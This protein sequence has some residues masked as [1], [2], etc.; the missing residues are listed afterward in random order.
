MATAERQPCPRC[1]QQHHV[2]T[3]CGDNAAINTF[4]WLPK[5]T[6][7][8]RETAA[9]DLALHG[10]HPE[11]RSVRQQ[12]RWR[13]LH[14]SSRTV[15]T[16][17]AFGWCGRLLLCIPP[18]LPIAFWAW[19]RVLFSPFGAYGVFMV[20]AALWWTKQVWA[21]SRLPTEHANA[22]PG[23][24]TGTGTPQGSHE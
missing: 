12:T 7:E 11:S 8:E 14:A 15:P 24:G 19:T 20:W 10:Q 18:Y 13:A 3:A 23:T 6:Y 17:T 5:A 2:R 1:A 16:T 9:R 22:R 4:T 21:S